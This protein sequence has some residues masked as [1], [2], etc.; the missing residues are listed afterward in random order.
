VREHP[1]VKIS[2]RGHDD[3][4]VSVASDVEHAP[5]G[6]SVVIRVIEGGE[7]CEPNLRGDDAWAFLTPIEARMVAE[8]LLQFARMLDDETAK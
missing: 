4:S 5:G 8:A 3:V 6:L 7:D 1:E 2:S